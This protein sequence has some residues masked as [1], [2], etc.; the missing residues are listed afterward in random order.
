VKTFQGC[1]CLLLCPPLFPPHCVKTLSFG[2]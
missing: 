2:L 1:C